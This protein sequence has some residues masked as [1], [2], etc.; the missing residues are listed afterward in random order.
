MEHQIPIFFYNDYVIILVNLDYNNRNSLNERRVLMF[1]KLQHLP[2]SM[3]SFS[4]WEQAFLYLGEY[5]K[6]HRQVDL[7][8]QYF[9][10]LSKTNIYYYLH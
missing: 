1:Y 10:K 2:E 9:K 3:P 6:D 8:M 7:V 5:V 4:S